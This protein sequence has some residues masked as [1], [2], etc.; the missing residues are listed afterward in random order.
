MGETR[1]FL[2]WIGVPVDG[3]GPVFWDEEFGPDVEPPARHRYST[4][5]QPGSGT[6][7]SWE[8]LLARTSQAEQMRRCAKKAKVANRPRLRS[9]APRTRITASEVWRVL[10]KAEGRCA[11]CGSLALEGR[12]SDPK[13]GAPLPWDRIGRRI[14]SLDHV[15]SRF[16]GGANKTWNLLW[17]CLWCNTWPQERRKG[18]LDHGGLYPVA[19]TR[20]P[21]R[22]AAKSRRSRG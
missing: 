5:K 22:V 3:D 18:A 12:P 11:Y 4:A 17:C 9:G 14:G 1:E 20:R 10:E 8:D 2:E 13:T 19:K 7:R 15:T 6:Y 16:V 21:R